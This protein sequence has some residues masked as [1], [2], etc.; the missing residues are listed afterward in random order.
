MTGRSEEA[1]WDKQW[2]L[3]GG[4]GDGEKEVSKIREKERRKKKRKRKEGEE[5]EYS[6]EE[7]PTSSISRL[8][9]IKFEAVVIPK[10][11]GHRIRIRAERGFAVLQTRR[12]VGV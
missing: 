2:G 8:P 6:K 1:V 3:L 4:R 12:K 7:R 11:T 9:D 5:G 10:D